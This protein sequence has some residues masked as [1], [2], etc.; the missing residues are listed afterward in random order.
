MDLTNFF[1]KEQVIKLKA[2]EKQTA[3][4]EMIDKLSELGQIENPVR[5]YTQVMH[6]ESEENT[7]I[8]NCFA[9]PH[10]RTETVPE[11]ISILGVAEEGID[12]QSYDGKPVQYIL[13]SI[14]PAEVSTKYL[15][16]IGMMARIFSSDATKSLI[17]EART[18]AKIYTLLK[19]E[20]ASYFGSIA[21]KDNN[22]MEVEESLSGVPS[23]D[24]DLIIRLDRLYNLLEEGQESE[25]INAKIDEVQKLVNNRSLTYYQRMKKKRNNPFAIV[26]KNSCSGCNLEIPPFHIRQIKERVGIPVCTHCGRFLIM[27]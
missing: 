24:L 15:Y 26:E 23:S 20:T 16:L 13:L 17:D 7:G 18:P 11:L 1:P 25:K 19:K 2:N 6:R 14:F 4:K 5:Y 22:A 3:L 8:G 9:I 21:E 12:Y 10:I 27:V